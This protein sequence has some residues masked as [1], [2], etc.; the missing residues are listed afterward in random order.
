M[1]RKHRTQILVHCRA[2][3]L[4][5]WAKRF[6]V[7]AEMTLIEEPATGLTMIKMR[8]SAQNS[9]FY[10]GEVEIS[11][12]RVECKGII[13]IGI[14]QGNELQKA[15]DLAVID[16]AYGAELTGIKE[17]E[18][19][20]EREELRQREERAKEIQSIMKTKVNFETMDV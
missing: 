19:D 11:E 12:A 17:F 16:A 10:L 1:K 7:E 5:K 9:L 18:K 13:G 4:R 14:I 3:F 15:Y 20:L 2:S 6:E 8:E